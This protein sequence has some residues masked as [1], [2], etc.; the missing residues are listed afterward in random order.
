M[1]IFNRPL[2]PAQIDAWYVDGVLMPVLNLPFDTDP[3]GGGGAGGGNNPPNG[4]AVGIWFE[5]Q[6]VSNYFQN[7]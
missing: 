5:R 4:N 7:K 1:V 6:G 2:T 3:A